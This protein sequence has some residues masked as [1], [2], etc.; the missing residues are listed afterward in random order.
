MTAPTGEVFP[1]ITA[2]KNYLQA[3]EG[4]DVADYYVQVD[5]PYAPVVVTWTYDG[6]ATSYLVEYATKSDFSDVITV[7]ADGGATS[8]DLYNLY[9]GS[10]YYV[11]VTAVDE[12]GANM[13]SGEGEF[14][15]TS[16]GPRVM[17]I[18][19]IYNVRD[20]GGYETSFG[21]TI[22]QG[23]AYRG[24]SLCVPGSGYAYPSILTE[25]GKAYMSEVMGIKGELDFRDPAEAGVSGDSLIPGATLTYI[26]AG[27]YDDIF[28]Q[29]KEK[30]RQ[31]F[32]YFADE[33]N[34]PIY[35]HCTGGADRT[36]TV[37]FLL[38]ALLGV[39]EMECIQGYEFTS[40]SIYRM[41]G[42]QSGEYATR[43][44]T[45]LTKMKTDYEGDTLQE[46]VENF[47]LSAGLT[48]MEIYNI[49]AIF[50]G[51][52][53]KTAVYA[54]ETY[55]KNV[56][57]DLVLPIAGGKTPSKLYLGGV[58]TE[59]TYANKKMTVAANKLPALAKG[60]VNGKVVFT[61]NT[62]LAFSFVYDEVN[63][64]FMDNVMSFG[65]DGT[66]LLTANREPL[67]GSGVVGYDHTACVR[68]TSTTPEKTDGGVRIFLGSYGVEIRGG[69]MRP[70]SIDANGNMKEVARDLK[71]GVPN[72][73][74]DEGATFYLTIDFVNDLPVLTMK[75]V[76]ENAVYEHSYSFA[77][78][79]AN[80]ISS[81]NAKMT[82]WIRTDAI[83]SLTIYNEQAWAKR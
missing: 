64:K 50:F 17:N 8:V 43:F 27:G 62:E 44:Q 59:F 60:N 71:M 11:R 47:F 35:Y 13:E 1:Y 46:K 39:S 34:Y 80:E 76:V 77:S 75:I 67:T 33:S 74:F 79:V 12:A 37:T 31:I 54:P 49:K 66:I 41:R 82:F 21:K 26:K 20:L 56:D 24:G 29:N 83:T 42:A 23:L 22:V 51:E 55:T 2:V 9:R 69:E 10:D 5:N 73:V 25:D 7:E 36:G 28:Y 30:Y 15:T 61:D 45:M 16:L 63:I 40:F 65:E 19:G 32:S 38:H 18:D 78:R 68:L 3:G 48:E 6:E 70:Y 72:K 58:E 4:A 52:P 14:Q 57:G 53:T 81:E